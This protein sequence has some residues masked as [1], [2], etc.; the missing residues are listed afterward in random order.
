MVPHPDLLEVSYDDKINF[1]NNLILEASD[2]VIKEGMSGLPDQT[3]LI[4]LKIRSDVI[5]NRK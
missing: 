5:A 3:V 2:R 1:L 4:L